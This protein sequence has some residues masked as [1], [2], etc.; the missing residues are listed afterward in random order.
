MQSI[1]AVSFQNKLSWVLSLKCLLFTHSLTLNSFSAELF[2]THKRKGTSHPPTTPTT[3]YSKHSSREIYKNGNYFHPTKRLHVKK[4]SFLY[5][6]RLS[7]LS[8]ASWGRGWHVGRRDFGRPK[9]LSTC[10]NEHFCR[11]WWQEPGRWV[12]H[13]KIRH[14]TQGSGFYN[15]VSDCPVISSFHL[16]GGWSM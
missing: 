9:A 14:L 4:D 3:K 6:I 7:I 1:C 11:L 5:Y 8:P 16:V 13:T 2:L 12:T 15:Q 10:P